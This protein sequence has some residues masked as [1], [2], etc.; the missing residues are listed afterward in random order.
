MEGEGRERQIL[1]VP[2]RVTIVRRIVTAFL[3]GTGQQ[4]IAETLNREKVPMFGKGAMWHRSY[5]SK[6]LTSQALIGTLVP[7]EVVYG[8]SGRRT[9]KALG[10]AVEGYFPPSRVEGREWDDL[11]A[12]LSKV[13]ARQPQHRKGL[14]TILAG[15]AECPLCGSAMTRV[16]K[17]SGPKGGRPKLVCT[18]A[19]T[20]AGCQYVALNLETLEQAIREGL[21]R[22]I[23]EA[24]SGDLPD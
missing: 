7:R 24:P 16:F 18:R 3:N 6:V 4:R 10:G 8:R 5:V 21:P 13:K 9:R 22:L 19:K 17:G 12:M 11:T 23:D 2:E 15:L 1:P 20:G 14:R